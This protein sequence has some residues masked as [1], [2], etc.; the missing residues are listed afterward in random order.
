MK[1]SRVRELDNLHP[2]WLDFPDNDKPCLTRGRTC[3][4]VYVWWANQFGWKRRYFCEAGH[5]HDVTFIFGKYLNQV[6]RK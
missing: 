4:R 1:A 5:W 3:R 6:R 2:K